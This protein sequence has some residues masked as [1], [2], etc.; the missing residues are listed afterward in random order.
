MNQSLKWA[1]SINYYALKSIRL[2][3]ELKDMT[4]ERDRLQNAIEIVNKKPRKKMS[5]FFVVFKQEKDGRFHSPVIIEAD[6]P[7]EAL[8]PEG[9]EEPRGDFCHRLYD[10]SEY[11]EL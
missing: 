5:Q 1:R 11:S 2:D 3:H 7:E 4:E 6:M 9:E 10:A 8:C